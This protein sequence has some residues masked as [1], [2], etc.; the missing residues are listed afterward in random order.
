VLVL[1][2]IVFSYISPLT[3]FIDAYRSSHSTDAQLQSLKQE[4]NRLAAQAAS[5]ND[6]NA[7]VEQARKLGLVQPGERSFV[8]KN[9]PH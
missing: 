8:V 9:L 3:N 1:F 7:A 2:A 5:L 4:H 6:P